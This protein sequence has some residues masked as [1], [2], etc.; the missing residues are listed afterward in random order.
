MNC[1]RASTAASWD[2]GELIRDS[3]RLY[4]KGSEGFEMKTHARHTRTSIQAAKGYVGPSDK[5]VVVDVGKD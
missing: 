1:R 5:R 3:E 2:L 4:D